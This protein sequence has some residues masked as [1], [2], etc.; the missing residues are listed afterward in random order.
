MKLRRQKYG[1]FDYDPLLV[2][3]S[4]TCGLG[5]HLFVPREHQ[6]AERKSQ[7]TMVS[8]T[9]RLAE[10]LKLRR[11]VHKAP[12]TMR[13]VSAS[14]PSLK[15]VEASKRGRPKTYKVF[16]DETRTKVGKVEVSFTPDERDDDLYVVSGSL[17]QGSF[18]RTV[19]LVHG[20][21]RPGQPHPG[22]A[23]SVRRHN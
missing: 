18:V 17:D 13:A 7:P 1:P 15:F 6:F 14:R 23:A 21:R 9:Y 22:F 20:V 19:H 2:A 4:A 8:A 5:E 10:P 3:I 16:L 11:D 12:Y